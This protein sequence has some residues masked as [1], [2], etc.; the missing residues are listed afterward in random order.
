MSELKPI[1][2]KYLDSWETA[3]VKPFQFPRTRPILL[4]RKNK[5]VHLIYPFRNNKMV[6]FYRSLSYDKTKF[7]FI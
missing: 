2:K 4:Y 7:I 6:I 1:D 5:I 3:Y